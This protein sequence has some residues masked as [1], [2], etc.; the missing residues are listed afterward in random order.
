MI[1][2]WTGQTV[3]GN[4]TCPRGK[5]LPSSHQHLQQLTRSILSQNILACVCA[6]SAAVQ[7]IAAGIER[8]TRIGWKGPMV[9]TFSDCLL[10]EDGAMLLA[11]LLAQCTRLRELDLQGSYIGPTGSGFLAKSLRRLT[12]LRSLNLAHDELEA[13]GQ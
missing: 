12:D 9:L 6:N 3:T 4:S 13:Q 5:C 10:G 11:S 1:G 2:N 8:A 7:M